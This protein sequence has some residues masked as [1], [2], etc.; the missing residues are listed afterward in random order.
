MNKAR[1]ETSTADA[2]AQPEANSEI[3]RQISSMAKGESD[4]GDAAFL[5][6]LIEDP[7]TSEVMSESMSLSSAQPTTSKAPI[8]AANAVAGDG[9]D[10]FG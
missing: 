9:C 2:D 6:S 1:D 3:S 7:E 8:A 5:K 10:G 4:A